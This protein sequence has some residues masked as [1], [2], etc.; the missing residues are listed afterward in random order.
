VWDVWYED[1]EFA[2]GLDINKMEHDIRYWL[3]Y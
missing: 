3:G 1:K 2:I